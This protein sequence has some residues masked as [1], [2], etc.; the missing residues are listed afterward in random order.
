MPGPFDI[1]HIDSERG[2]RGGESQLLYLAAHLRGRGC[3]NTIACPAGSALETEARRQGFATLVLPFW[4]DFDPVSAWK[5]RRFA[6]E[7][8]RASGRRTILHAHTGHAAGI[9]ALAA[10]DGLPWVAHRRV[11]FPLRGP[12]G[13][14]KYRSAARIVAVSGSI[15]AVLEAAG[16]P[17]ARIAVIPDC[18]P[19]TEEEARTAGLAAGPLRPATGEERTA[20]R[21]LLESE[22]GIPAEAPLV[23]NLAALVP[24]KDQATLLRAA[25]LVLRRL[26]EARFV[27]LGDGP[28]RSELEGLVSS[29]GIRTAVLLP[30]RQPDPK[31]WLRSLDLYV[32]SSWGEGM[33]SVILEAMACRIPVAA[34]RAGGIPEVV[35]DGT[36]GR[37]APPRDPQALAETILDSLQ[38]GPAARRRAQAAGEALERFGLARLGDEMFKVYEEAA[39]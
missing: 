2:F 24:H 27:I 11:D 5:L 29:L 38:D 16:L 31:P 1:L 15:R 12:L 14:L 20:L 30:G 7:A 9:A 26:P 32:Q 21:G 23:G 37:L 25:A 17:A 39:G 13:R 33:G 35:T 8:A 10:A 19:L 28:L 4:T 36:S 22:Y 34:T 6:G 18:I 3:A